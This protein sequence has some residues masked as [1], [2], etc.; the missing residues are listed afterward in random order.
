MIWQLYSPTG[1][2]RQKQP[3]A[4]DPT[5]N[6]LPATFKSLRAGCT[7]ADSGLG[8]EKESVPLWF[9]AETSS[10]QESFFERRTTSAFG[11]ASALSCAGGKAAR[12][13]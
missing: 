9:M 11:K 6:P 4:S 3:T 8:K 1:L 13:D 7:G 10:V 12:E 2:H 5:A